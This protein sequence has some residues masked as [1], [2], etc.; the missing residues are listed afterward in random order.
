MS[1]I[2]PRAQSRLSLVV[3]LA[4]RLDRF[5]K[6]TVGRPYN[7]ALGAG[8]V[9]SI[10]ATVRT[11]ETQLSSR[12]NLVGLGFA[13]LFEATL[14]INQLAQLHEFREAVRTRREARQTEREARKADKPDT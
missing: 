5:L 3:G 1:Q 9:L 2:E 12:A 4:W 14:L 13:V 7:M 6:H 11:I 8:L 10:I